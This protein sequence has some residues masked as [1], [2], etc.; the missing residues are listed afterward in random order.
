VK[1]ILITVYAPLW[2]LFTESLN[3]PLKLAT[4]NKPMLAKI[5]FQER[6]LILSAMGEVLLTA[7]SD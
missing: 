3:S 4:A 6:A 1:E 2:Q 5:N 7:G